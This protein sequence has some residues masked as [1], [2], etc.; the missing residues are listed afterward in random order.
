MKMKRHSCV[1]MGTVLVPLS[2]AAELSQEGQGFLSNYLNKD[3][4]IILSKQA[5]EN[6]TI[7]SNEAE[8]NG[9]EDEDEWLSVIGWAGDSSDSSDTNERPFP[10]CRVSF[11]V[12]QP[13]CAQHIARS[14]R[15]DCECYSFCGGDLVECV[16]Y[17]DDVPPFS[18]PSQD[19]M[20]G[21]QENTTKPDIEQSLGIDRPCPRGYICSKYEQQS[22]E[23]VRKIPIWLGLGDVH[24][25]LSCP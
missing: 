1:L 22:C 2:M 21:C 24:A 17:G 18:C 15:S 7:V 23:L 4:H 14:G 6:T 13:S 5:E 9:S 20:V 16:G 19:V 25:G 12:S 8:Q 11:N 10:T 3:G